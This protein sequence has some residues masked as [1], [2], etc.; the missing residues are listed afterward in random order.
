MSPLDLVFWL[1]AALGVIA[2]WLSGLLGF[3]SANPD[4]A[5]GAVLA[6]VVYTI[7]YYVSRYLIKVNLPRKQMHK[8]ITTGLGS[9]IMLFLF[10]WIL[11][12]TFVT[13]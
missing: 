3:V 1:R 8:L 5:R 6:V 9:F 10:T 13:I 12:N 2:G 11:Y 7:S 4:A